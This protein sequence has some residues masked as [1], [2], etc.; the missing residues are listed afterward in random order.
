MTEH[1]ISADKVTIHRW[2]SSTS[3]PVRIWATDAQFKD[4]RKK[5]FGK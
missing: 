2:H 5:H 1:K 3:C 4:W